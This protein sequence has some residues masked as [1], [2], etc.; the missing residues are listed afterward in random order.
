MSKYKTIECEFRNGQSLL[1]ALAD[2]GFDKVQT[3]ISKKNSLPMV[4][5]HGDT[6]PETVSIRI[7]R[8]HITSV[9]NDVGFRWNGH[10]YEAIISEYDSSAG[11]PFS[12][13]GQDK[14]KQRYAYHE[15][16]RIAYSKGYNVTEKNGQ[17]GEIS[18]VLSRR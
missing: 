9:S 2:L 12:Q 8:T 10:S 5:Y 11:C 6:R 14:L 1:K 18:L 4:G 7:E 17:N 13:L 15:T 16:R 3:D